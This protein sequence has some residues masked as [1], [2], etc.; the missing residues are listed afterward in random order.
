M[1]KQPPYQDL[2]LAV[3]Q[4]GK[5]VTTEDIMKQTGLARKSIHGG[6]Y[7]LSRKGHQIKKMTLFYI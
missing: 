5:P 2:I 4:R 3:L 1:S 6:I 7:R